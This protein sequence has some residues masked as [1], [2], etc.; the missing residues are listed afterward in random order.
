[1]KREKEYIYR[2]DGKLLNKYAII[3]CGNGYM[4][5]KLHYDFDNNGRY[6]IVSKRYKYIGNASKALKQFVNN[7]W[8]TSF[9]QKSIIENNLIVGL[10]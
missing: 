2:I 8:K 3:N 6:E 4:I 7:P 5:A 10:K 1:M 9:A